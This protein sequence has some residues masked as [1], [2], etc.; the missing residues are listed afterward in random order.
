[1]KRE[2]IRRENARALAAEVGGAA[3]FG[4][5]MSMENTQVSHII[6]PNPIRNIGNS[7]AP[8]I[9]DVFGKE[10]GWLDVLHGPGDIDTPELADLVKIYKRLSPHGKTAVMTVARSLAGIVEPEH[11]AS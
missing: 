7:L 5:R 4:R 6:G 9:E 1:M 3:E 2:D 11:P 8:R 10:R